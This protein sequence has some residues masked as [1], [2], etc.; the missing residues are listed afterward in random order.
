MYIFCKGC[1]SLPFALI[2][3]QQND[4]IKPSQNNMVLHKILVLGSG[5]KVLGI[6][7]KN[8]SAFFICKFQAYNT[9]KQWFPTF[10]SPQNDNAWHYYRGPE[11]ERGKFI[12]PGKLDGVYAFTIMLSSITVI[13]VVNRKDIFCAASSP[14]VKWI[15]EISSI[16][17][18]PL[19]SKQSAIFHLHSFSFIQI[20]NIHPQITF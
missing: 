8:N 15:W 10:L 3:S 12:A 17:I 4:Q 16:Y 11:S 7:N 19:N 18:I 5:F 1:F 13:D 20:K 2:N 14:V 6:P 9:I